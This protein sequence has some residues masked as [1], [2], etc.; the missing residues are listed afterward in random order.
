MKKTLCVAILATLLTVS[1][2]CQ[3][4]GGSLL[5]EPR[6]KQWAPVASVKLYSLDDF[7]NQKK[8]TAEI[9]LLA[10]MADTRGL[11]AT[12]LVLSFELGGAVRILADRSP[13]FGL[14]IGASVKF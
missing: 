5:Y 13:S 8:I 7:M 9:R 14:V 4:L 6:T 10:G 11:A 12:A 1:A 3:Q 2:Y